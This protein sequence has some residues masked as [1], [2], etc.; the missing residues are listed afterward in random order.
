MP[1]AIFRSGRQSSSDT[2]R[3]IAT[4]AES[5]IN[6]LLDRI[7]CTTDS[8]TNDYQMIRDSDT[9]DSETRDSRTTVYTI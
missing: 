9:R 4:L 2:E 3:D 6:D 7:K 8:D 5:T 1:I